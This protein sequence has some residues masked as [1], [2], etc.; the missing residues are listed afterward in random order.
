[1]ETSWQASVWADPHKPLAKI[2][3]T[4]HQCTFALTRLEKW[5]VNFSFVF[6]FLW[7]YL[8]TST[9]HSWRGGTQKE[10]WKFCRGA[11]EGHR[12]KRH[13]IIWQHVTIGDFSIVNSDSNS[14]EQLKDVAEEWG[15]LIVYYRHDSNNIYIHIPVNHWCDDVPG[16]YGTNISF[17]Y[18]C[19]KNLQPR[20]EQKTIYLSSL[21]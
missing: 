13:V 21:V 9:W 20:E 7:Q 14:S 16:P 11:G 2:K 1:M 5:Q 17:P 8:L 10:D 15:R 18:P 3:W 19:P 4:V 12:E 6:F